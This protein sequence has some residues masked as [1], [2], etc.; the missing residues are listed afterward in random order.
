MDGDFDSSMTGPLN[1][2]T[3]AL[4]KILHRPKGYLWVFY[5]DH[6]IAASTDVV[7]AVRS[8]EAEV[9]NKY[10]NVEPFLFWECTPG[11]RTNWYAAVGFVIAEEPA[12]MT[13]E[14]LDLAR[15]AKFTIG[16]IP[17]EIRSGDLSMA[18]LKRSDTG[19]LLATVMFP[20]DG[21]PF[22]LSFFRF[23]DEHG[24]VIPA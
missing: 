17:A 1:A 16:G 8:V 19:R 22:A 11:F 13:M 12:R 24:K 3:Y 7:A 5:P 10:A 21:D 14:H 4:W 18:E 15:N 6:T 20:M 9:L 2:D 23:R